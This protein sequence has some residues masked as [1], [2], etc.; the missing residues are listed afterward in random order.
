MQVVP[1]HMQQ[2]LLLLLSK[3]IR[4]HFEVPFSML[5]V[6]H[7]N[8]DVDLCQISKLGLFDIFPKSKTKQAMEEL[9][10]CHNFQTFVH[11]LY[12][13]KNLQACNPLVQQLYHDR[14]ILNVIQ[15]D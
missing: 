11:L 14:V 4:G 1:G 10:K 13:S 15:F 12:W 3:A 5:P 8:D 6:C 9:K 2:Q 7:I